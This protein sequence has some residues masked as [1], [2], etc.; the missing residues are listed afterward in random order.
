MKRFVK[1]IVTAVITLTLSVFA[2][3][4]CQDGGEG[5]GAASLRH[6]V[7]PE[8]K[9]YPELMPDINAKDKFTL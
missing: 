2:L 3:T 1:V 6:N 8:G 5:R 7:F 4:A 9:N